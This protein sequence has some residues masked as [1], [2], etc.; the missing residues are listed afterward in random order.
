MN[1]TFYKLPFENKF[2]QF[3]YTLDNMSGKSTYCLNS[4][5]GGNNFS[6]QSK[7]TKNYT[8]DHFSQR[9]I[10]NYSKY[11]SIN[12]SS[13]N[14]K[15]ASDKYSYL[16]ANTKTN[17]ISNK[18][19]EIETNDL[20]NKFAK[21]EI[22]VN[23]LKNLSLIAK[24]KTKS[25]TNSETKSDSVKLSIKVSKSNSVKPNSVKPNSVKLNKSE[26][27]IRIIPKSIGSSSSTSNTKKLFNLN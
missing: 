1:N 3:D 10:N 21:Q 25:N 4:C 27:S 16:D 26:L 20:S 8:D 15:N 14:Y 24:S 17:S 22:G 7:V 13:A 11:D 12:M 19:S 6:K 5:M 18:Y 23:K 2:N 9:Y